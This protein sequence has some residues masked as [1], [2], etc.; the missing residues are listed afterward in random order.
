MCSNKDP[1]QP[2][3]SSKTHSNTSGKKLEDLFVS[4]SFAVQFHTT[5]WNKKIFFFVGMPAKGPRTWNQLLLKSDR[6]GRFYCTE[7]E[8]PSQVNWGKRVWKTV[9]VRLLLNFI[10]LVAKLKYI[11]KKKVMFYSCKFPLGTLWE[12]TGLASY[13]FVNLLALNRK[14]CSD[15][16]NQ[17]VYSTPPPRMT[18]EV[19]KMTS[20][21]SLF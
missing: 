21:R 6:F 8:I 12:K 2:P 9:P 18:E 5:S 4:G 20:S 11:W 10:W 7:S 14:A 17:N 15:Q 16:S 13:S 3:A 19:T 1:A